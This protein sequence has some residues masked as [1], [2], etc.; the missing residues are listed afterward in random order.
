MNYN[1]IRCAY[2]GI[3]KSV[4]G[5]KST[6][7]IAVWNRHSFHLQLL[8]KLL[9]ARFFVLVF[10]VEKEHEEGDGLVRYLMEK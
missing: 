5:D 1:A 2:S 4:W 8:S 10:H 6:I 3:S 7:S 9:R